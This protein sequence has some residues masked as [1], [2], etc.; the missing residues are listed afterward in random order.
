MMDSA[1]V[2]LVLMV[3]LVV[4]VPLLGRAFR[5]NRSLVALAGIT[6]VHLAMI[7]LAAIWAAR[8]DLQFLTPERIFFPIAALILPAGGILALMLGLILDVPWWKA[9]AVAAGSYALVV[10]ASD[11]L[12]LGFA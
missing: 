12:L 8:W 4:V 10:L 7:A 5:V 1:Q 11:F 2:Y 3:L 6:L 9:I